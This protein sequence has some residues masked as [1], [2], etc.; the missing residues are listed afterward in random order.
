MISEQFCGRLVLRTQTSRKE[1]SVPA[2]QNK[3]GPTQSNLPHH[4]TSSESSSLK[5]KKNIEFFP[6]CILRG[7][8]FG[9]GCN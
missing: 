8:R 4:S 2:T 3:T 9:E 7:N 6:S 5:H 1:A